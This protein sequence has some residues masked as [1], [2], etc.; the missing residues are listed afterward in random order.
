M[1]MWIYRYKNN[2]LYSRYKINHL[3]SKMSKT[4]EEMAKCLC[5]VPGIRKKLLPANEAKRKA[6]VMKL[7]AHPTRLQILRLLSEKDLCV[8]VLSEVIGKTQPNVSQHLAKLKDNQMIEDY[9]V[10]KLVFYRLKDKET[11]KLIKN[12]V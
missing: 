4:G 7:F 11:R 2:H 9:S 5:G 12:L 3:H 1:I 10:G 6:C 8:C